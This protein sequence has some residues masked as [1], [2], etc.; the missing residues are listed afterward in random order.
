MRLFKSVFILFISF[1]FSS[2][3]FSQNLKETSDYYFEK[4]A[5]EQGTAMNSSI[6]IFQDKIGYI[7]ITSQAG[8]DRFDGYKFTNFANIS[9]DS[10][11]TNLRWVNSINQDSKGNIWATDQFGNISNYNRFNEEWNNYY[12]HYKDSIKNVP[13]GVYG[14]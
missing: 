1:S 4:Y 13:K 14:W 3:I 2:N 12:P 6:R 10:T 8:L 9:S 11:S 7:W 5:V